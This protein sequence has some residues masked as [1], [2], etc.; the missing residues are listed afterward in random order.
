M[1]SR[2]FD[3]YDVNGDGVVSVLELMNLIISGEAS[4]AKAF[5]EEVKKIADIME[6]K[7]LVTPLGAGFLDLESYKSLVPKPAFKSF[8]QER[9][10]FITQNKYKVFKDLQDRLNDEYNS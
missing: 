10:I 2:C 8:L 5:E 9:L 3:V 4:L 7:R 1:H 6:Q